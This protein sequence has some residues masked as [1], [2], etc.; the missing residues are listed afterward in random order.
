MDLAL[1]ARTHGVPPS[2][3]APALGLDATQVERVYTAIDRK[4]QAARRSRL[5]PLLVDHVEDRQ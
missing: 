2:V 3:A 5:A 4:R 1:Y